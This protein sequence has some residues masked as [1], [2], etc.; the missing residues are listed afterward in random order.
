MKDVALLA[1]KEGLY[2][3]MVSNGFVESEPL[4]EIIKFIDAF[5][6]DLKAFNNTFY[7]NLT[8]SELEP[9]KESLKQ[10]ANSDKHLEVT[11][12][13]IPGQNDDEKEMALQTE[14]MANELGPDV[15]FHLSGYFPTYKRDDP[16]TSEELLQR[17]SD[18]AS[19]NLN[20]VYT[21][22]TTSHTGQNTTCP[23]CGTVVTYRSGYKTRLA[24]LD[25]EGK[26]LN[27]GNQIYKNFISS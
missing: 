17:L 24:N 21:G 14:W 15:P 4:E 16:A 9:V 8:G 5:N 6:I 23:V 18:I 13:I 11:T 12:L 26:C 20:F 25:E 1:S 19:K 7:R 22:N 2:T 27:C 10:I 3:V